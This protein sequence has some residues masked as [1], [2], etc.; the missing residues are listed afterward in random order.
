MKTA[1]I[2]TLA[3]VAFASAAAHAQS[4][5]PQWQQMFDG[6][7]LTG[8]KEAA[9]RNPGVLKV[10]DGAIMLE[11]GNPLTGAN[12][13]GGEFPK[14]NYEL[15]F[16]A[17][18]MKGNDFFA[19]LTAPSGESFFTLVTGGWGGDIVGVSNIDGWDASEN[20][21]RTYF[22]FEDERWYRFRLQVTPDQIQIW[23]DDERVINVKITGREVTLRPGPISL[24]KPLGFA[25]YNS[26]GG[27]R[28]IEYRRL[29]TK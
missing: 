1:T 26:T 7:T 8:W 25:S 20:E 17:V 12:W 19:S 21:T 28:K 27:I 6:K 23:I 11:H 18:R 9:F 14:T 24:C 15:R 22:N 5:Q 3:L 10:V 4:S 29:V 13:V 2:G 16:E